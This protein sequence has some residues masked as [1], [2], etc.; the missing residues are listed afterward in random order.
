MAD[1]HARVI[2]QPGCNP[3]PTVPVPNSSAPCG[4]DP[5][6]ICYAFAWALIVDV[7]T[8]R[9]GVRFTPR[10]K[11]WATGVPGLLGALAAG[12]AVIAFGIWLYRRPAKCD[13]E[14]MSHGATCVSKS[15]DREIGSQTY[16]EVLE[17]QQLFAVAVMAVGALV[18]LVAL[19]FAS[20]ALRA[21]LTAW[22]SRRGVS[23]I[24]PRP[25]TV[26]LLG[27]VALIAGGVAVGLNVDAVVELAVCGDES[28]ATESCDATSTSDAT[29]KQAVA[30][31][32]GFVVA[33]GGL[34]AGI[35]GVRARR[36]G[37]WK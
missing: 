13:G 19:G 27:L 11:E 8:P 26:I 7:V 1:R 21:R 5:I 18:I 22:R 31:I 33:A 3:L 28:T 2:L 36:A 9:N 12:A 25:I 15:G 32:G 16:E 10:F 37:T 29:T 4:N 35:V 23:T 6:R 14:E 20:G 24:T 30:A 34:I 17:S